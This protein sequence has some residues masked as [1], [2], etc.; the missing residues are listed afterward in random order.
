MRREAVHEGDAFLD[1][2]DGD[3]FIGRVG[4]KD[5]TRSADHDGNLK[6]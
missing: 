4:L 3:E 6:I 1:L 2:I 5:V